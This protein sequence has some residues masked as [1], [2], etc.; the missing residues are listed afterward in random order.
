MET[1]CY[2]A[3]MSW[4]NALCCCVLVEVSRLTVF[5]KALGKHVAA[6]KTQ[7]DGGMGGNFSCFGSL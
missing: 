2:V 4:K 7:A 1:P 5:P 3:V 6:I